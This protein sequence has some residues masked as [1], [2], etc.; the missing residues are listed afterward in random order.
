MV[1][2]T[3][4]KKVVSSG[5]SMLYEKIVAKNVIIKKATHPLSELFYLSE[6][7][8]WA[9]QTQIKTSFEFQ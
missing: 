7:T 1:K 4:A 5:L 3:S 8:R 2:L 6:R 9:I